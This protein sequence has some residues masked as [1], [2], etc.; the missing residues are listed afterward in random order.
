MIMK[1]GQEEEEDRSFGHEEKKK[2][3]LLKRKGFQKQSQKGCISV[4]KEKKGLVRQQG[5][6]FYEKERSFC[7]GEQMWI[8]SDLLSLWRTE[9]QN[10]RLRGDQD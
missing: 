5:L 6:C 8:V 2:K 1:E 4:R 3:K 7:R 10:V 9:K